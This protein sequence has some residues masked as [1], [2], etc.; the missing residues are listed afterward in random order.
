MA[1]FAD[2]YYFIALISSRDAGHEK[3]AQF[4]LQNRE[5]IV[6]T[7]WILTELAD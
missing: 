4:S 3:A 1:I 6:T 2:T 7:E 5:S